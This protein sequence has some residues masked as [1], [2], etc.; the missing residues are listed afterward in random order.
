[1]PPLV[2][3]A[4]ALSAMQ[5]TA[6]ATNAA[7]AADSSFLCRV[8]LPASINIEVRRR[9]ALAIKVVHGTALPHSNPPRTIAPNDPL[10]L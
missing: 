5:A 7:C 10:R 2:D 1:M 4:L 8:V 3:F 9:Y 6:M